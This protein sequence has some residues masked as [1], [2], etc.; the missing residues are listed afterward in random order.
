VCSESDKT[1]N[2]YADRMR[3]LEMMRGCRRHST[4]QEKARYLF[5][6]PATGTVSMTTLH[7]R[8][9]GAMEHVWV[10]P[11]CSDVDS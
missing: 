3:L 5:N 11:E 4:L 10:C 6:Q 1:E 8:L 9:Q 7:R 2:E